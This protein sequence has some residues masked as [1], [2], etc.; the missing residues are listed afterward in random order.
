[1]LEIINYI[2]FYVCSRICKLAHFLAA[3]VDFQFLLFQ[4]VISDEHFYLFEIS[5]TELSVG[6]FTVRETRDFS[7]GQMH[8]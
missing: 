2:A 7:L 6:T 4:I 1:M 8:F 5:P 3:Y